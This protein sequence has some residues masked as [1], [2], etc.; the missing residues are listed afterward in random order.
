[1]SPSLSWSWTLKHIRKPCQ[2]RLERRYRLLS[3][4]CM[5][6]ES[7]I[8]PMGPVQQYFAPLRKLPQD[9]HPGKQSQ[10]HFLEEPLRKWLLQ[11]RKRWVLVTKQMLIHCTYCMLF[12]GNSS[13]CSQCKHPA[14]CKRSGRINLVP[15]LVRC[16]LGTQPFARAQSAVITITRKQ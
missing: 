11:R 8:G 1:M 2:F 14:S 15:S 7:A 3:S 16:R 10:Y 4:L 5:R 9:L 6:G 13:L 12:C